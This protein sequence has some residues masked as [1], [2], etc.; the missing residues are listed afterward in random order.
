MTW[1][2]ISDDLLKC[3]WFLP[4]A[5]K[6]RNVSKN[7]RPDCFANISIK[8]IRGPTIPRYS[9]SPEFLI[10]PD[11]SYG[12]FFW[13]LQ[14]L[15]L[16]FATSLICIKQDLTEKQQQQLQRGLSPCELSLLLKALFTSDTFMLTLSD[17]SLFLLIWQWKTSLFASFLLTQSFCGINYTILF[18]SGGIFLDETWQLGFRERGREGERERWCG[19]VWQTLQTIV[20]TG[21]IQSVSQGCIS[22]QQNGKDLECCGLPSFYLFAK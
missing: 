1:L 21:D 20:A 7:R 16:G 13:G 10:G 11:I 2:A 15:V 8:S 3:F 12:L 22:F 9:S 18:S 14:D 5:N 17:N 4:P 19:V 6:I